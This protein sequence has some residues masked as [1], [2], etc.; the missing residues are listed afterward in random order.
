MRKL[1]LESA[2]WRHLNVKNKQISCE[3]RM[4]CENCQQISSATTIT[5]VIKQFNCDW[6]S[7]Q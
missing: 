2:V 3:N 6:D 4:S 1:Y 5:T 7:R